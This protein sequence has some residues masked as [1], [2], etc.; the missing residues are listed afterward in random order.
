MTHSDKPESEKKS[1][2]I[3]LSDEPGHEGPITPA[4]LAI[5]LQEIGRAT[6]ALVRRVTASGEAR[7][8]SEH[9]LDRVLVIHQEEADGLQHNVRCDRCG[10]KSPGA[11]SHH[12][13]SALAEQMGWDVA[14]EYD[15]CPTCRD[16]GVKQLRAGLPP[17]TSDD[18]L[19]TEPSILDQI[20]LTRVEWLAERFK[21]GATPVATI[22]N[23]RRSGHRSMLSDLARSFGYEETLFFRKLN[24]LCLS[25]R[26]R[27]VEAPDE[28][29]QNF[30]RKLFL[31][32]KV[33]DGA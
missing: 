31:L 15:H 8:R 10:L 6:D 27:V 9:L 30:I 26:R 28:A 21:S 24:S 16:G 20:F 17:D 5:G 14:D 1:D 29:E 3:A 2:A 25:E 11:A 32:L 23:A 19:P 13:A 18:V 12:R 33:E 22:L 4:E 7:D